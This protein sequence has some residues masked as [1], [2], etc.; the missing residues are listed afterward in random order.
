MASVIRALCTARVYCG[1]ATADK[2]PMIKTT[3]NS[4]IS[5]NPRLFCTGYIPPIYIS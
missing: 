3:T 1:K 4:S 2:I 5:V